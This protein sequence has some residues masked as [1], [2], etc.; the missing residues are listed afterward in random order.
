MQK[1]KI[2]T[3]AVISVRIYSSVFSKLTISPIIDICIVIIIVITI[4]LL[5]YTVI[6]RSV[7][8]P[9]MFLLPMQSVGASKSLIKIVFVLLISVSISNKNI[10]SLSLYHLSFLFVSCVFFSFS[11]LVL[12]CN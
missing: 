10:C 11:I 12:A 3:K 8:Q 9:D 6:S 1:K 4:I 5:A 2:R 7:P